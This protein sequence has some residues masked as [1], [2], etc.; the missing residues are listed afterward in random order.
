MLLEV[1]NVSKEYQSGL[2]YTRT[3]PAVHKVSFGLEAGEIFG[4]IGG[5]GCGKTTMIKMILGLQKPT[6]GSIMFEGKDLTKLKKKEW[7]EMHREIQVVFQHPQMTFNPRGTIRF[8]CAEPA[9]NYGLV[10]NR[11]EKQRLVEDTGAAKA[12]LRQHNV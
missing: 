6:C 7:K 3:I 10:K 5:S 1:D 12:Y 4:L 11:D 2:F 9:V 8:A